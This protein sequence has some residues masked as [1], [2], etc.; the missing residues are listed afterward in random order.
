[1]HFP[2][3]SKP[4]AVVEALAPENV[5]LCNDAILDLVMTTNQDLV[6]KIQVLPGISD[7]NLVL[8]DINM[9]PTRVF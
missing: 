7:H 6:E 3:V 9:G 2:S 1:M 8:F 5:N 4:I